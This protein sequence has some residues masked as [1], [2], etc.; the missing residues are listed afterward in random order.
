MRK[1]PHAIFCFCF[2]LGILIREYFPF[3]FN[4]IPV[5]L[6][7]LSVTMIS[8]FSKSLEIVKL[9]KIFTGFSFLLLGVVIHQLNTRQQQIPKVDQKETIIFKLEKK[10]NSNE[11]NRRYEIVAKTQNEEFKSILSVPKTDPELDFKNYYQAQAYINQVEPPK[12]DYQFN[13]AKYLQRKNIYFQSYLPNGYKGQERNDLNWPEKVKQKRTE[14]LQKIDNSNMSPK[15]REFLKGFILADRTEIDKETVSN[16]SRTGLAHILAISGS[17]IVVIYMILFWIFGQIYSARFRKAAIITSLLF[18]WLFAIF[19][20][21]GNPVIRSCIM[22]TIYYVYVLLQRKPDLLH[23]MALAA[24]LILIVDSQQI[25]DVGFQLSF[26]A[27]LGIYWLNFPILN[28]FPKYRNKAQVYMYSIGSITLAA[29]FAT[30]PLVLFYFHQFSLIS[31]VANLVI[32]PIA[33]IIIIYSMFLAP[34][35]GM[36]IKFSWIFELYDFLVSN[37]LVLIRWFAGFESVFSKNIPFSL[38]EVAVSIVALYYLRFLILKVEWKSILRFSSA[39][40][41]LL[42][43]HFGLNQYY[44]TVDEVMI[45]HHFKEKY[46][47]VKESKQVTFWLPENSDLEKIEKYVIDPYLT[48]RRT[49]KYTVK[50]LPPNQ[51]SFRYGGKTYYLDVKQ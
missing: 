31:F 36:G 6:F 22:L 4:F 43:L 49:R 19:I 35:A 24:F 41:V 12:N 21:Y 15:S 10:L 16:F 28:R 27:V 46:I 1:Q 3:L 5:F 11:R 37:V 29:Q 18:I 14:I 8:Y 48:S 25:F 26:I 20:D 7:V 44:K 9:R 38:A 40:G 2:I 47:S 45:H 50:K 17:H 51:T 34:M 33:E 39:F 13:Y 32:I 42:V 30:L 23:A